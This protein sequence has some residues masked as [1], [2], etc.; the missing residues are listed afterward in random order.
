MDHLEIEVK[1]PV[2]ETGALHRAITALGCQSRGR[3]FETNFCYDDENSSLMRKKA[4]LRLR[5]DTR[6]TLTFKSVPGTEDPRFKV[7]REM[8]VNIDSFDTM[9]GILEAIGFHRTQVY[10]K[11]RETFACRGTELCLDTLPFGTFLE[12]E[13]PP[14]AITGI[15]RE[16]NLAWDRRILANYLEMFDHLRRRLTLPFSDLTFDNFRG[17]S[18]DPAWSRAFAAGS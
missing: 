7:L 17:V 12:I 15:S 9:A 6:A 2:D 5:N 3:V 4:L 8:E 10:E 11:W 18:L 1:F 13:G 16:L 14:A